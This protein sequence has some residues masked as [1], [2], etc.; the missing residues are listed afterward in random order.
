MKWTEYLSAKLPSSNYVTAIICVCVLVVL[1]VLAIYNQSAYEQYLTGFWS[2]ENDEFCDDSG[3]ES[4]LLYVGSPT[5]WTSATR[6]CYLIITDDICNQLVTMSYRRGWSGIGISKYNIAATLD[7]QDDDSDKSDPVMP[8]R[9]SVCVNMLD[10]TLEI[11]DNEKVYARLH[12]QHDIT[13]LT[14]RM[15]SSSDEPVVDVSAKK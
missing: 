4:M 15:K 1:Y 12:K 6:R 11:R 9:V 3:I 14:S 13:N 8:P 2:A 5:G 10:G 7:F